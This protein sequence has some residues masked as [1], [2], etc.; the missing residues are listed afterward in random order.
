[1]CRML[2]EMY[3]AT[4]GHEDLDDMLAQ[5]EVRRLLVMRTLLVERLWP[6][7]FYVGQMGYAT[8]LR[9]SDWGACSMHGAHA[10]VSA[11]HPTC[12]G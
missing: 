9:I 2:G 5:V 6:T 1:M 10:Q 3:G 11:A 7:L 8:P 4:G 12:V